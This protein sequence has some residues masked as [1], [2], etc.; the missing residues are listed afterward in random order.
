MCRTP[1][2]AWKPQTEW[3]TRLLFPLIRVKSVPM[4][5]NGLVL[6]FRLPVKVIAA[7]GVR[8][9][10]PELEAAP[11]ATRGTED[12]PSCPSCSSCQQ[13]LWLVQTN[14]PAGQDEQD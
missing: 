9:E 7:L 3:V 8:Y 12:H 1:K 13:L 14:G 5:P 2:P 4:S 11:P 6:A 10:T